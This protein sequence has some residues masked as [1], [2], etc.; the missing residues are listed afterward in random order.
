MFEKIKGEVPSQEN[1]EESITKISH[2]DVFENQ[3][4]SREEFLQEATENILEQNKSTTKKRIQEV[5]SWLKKS[6]P[7][8][9]KIIKSLEAEEKEEKEKGTFG[10][11]RE[12]WGVTPSDCRA[13][14]I[15]E[16]IFNPNAL[17]NRYYQEKHFQSNLKNRW[18]K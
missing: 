2:E 13:A 16:F 4:D 3:K 9:K 15:G 7:E 8:E 11:L 10:M 12:L 6:C 5:R 14:I 18:K 17:K 1:K